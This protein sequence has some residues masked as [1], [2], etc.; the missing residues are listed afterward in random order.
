MARAVYIPTTCKSALNRVQGMPFRWSLNPYR[1]C[2]HGCHYCY[3]MATHAYYGLD[4][5]AFTSAIFVKSNLLD[6]LRM[7]LARPSWCGES[8]SI[9]TATD[10]YQPCEGRYCLTRGALEIFHD[11]AN[12]VTIVT[13]STLI[14]RDL[15]L[16]KRLAAEADVTV[17]FTVTT[18]DPD[19]WRA[20]EPH[21]PPP[22]K[23]LQAMARLADAGVRTGVFMAPVVPAIT[24]SYERMAQVARA[25]REHGA[26]SFGASVLRLA[27]LVKDHWLGFVSERFP[28]LLI[29]YERSFHDGH[30]SPAYLQAMEA[31]L[32]RVR[33]EAGFDI[34]AMRRS[35][36]GETLTRRGRQLA[37]PL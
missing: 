26:D 19:L 6:V 7:E 12:P 1:G 30:A 9:G 33:S 25:A 13:K 27:P 24:D 34:D 3:A 29:R 20:I 31:R 37:L 4:T 14:V 18:L 21:T 5:D 2:T 35:P 22:R 36:R 16:L 17:Y 15:D 11:F 8:V 10:P 23:R 32:E 28:D